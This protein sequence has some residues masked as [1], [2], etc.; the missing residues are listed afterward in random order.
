M[1]FKYDEIKETYRR[2]QQVKHGYTDCHEPR[3]FHMK[4][5]LRRKNSVRQSVEQNV[6]DN[7]IIHLQYHQNNVN[8]M[9]RNILL[10]NSSSQRRINQLT[11]SSR[12]ER[13]GD[14]S[15]RSSR[16][17]RHQWDDRS[18]HPLEAEWRSKRPNSRPNSTQKSNG[19]RRATT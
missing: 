17:G 9:M 4:E 19:L 18:S 7:I 1:R 16:S 8:S 12:L 2:V 3:T 14:T 6:I 15:V 10:I 13:R 11:N 5:A